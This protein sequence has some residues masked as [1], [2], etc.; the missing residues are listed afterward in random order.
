MSDDRLAEIEAR[1]AAA[2]PGPWHRLDFA[3][4]ANDVWIGPSF[5]N[6]I[7]QVVPD[8][9][10]ADAAFIAHAREDVPWLLAE[11]RRLR[12]IEAAA[13]DVLDCCEAETKPC[14]LRQQILET[15]LAAKP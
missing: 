11:V 1:E 14:S 8:D 7:A 2:T 10:S 9:A 3:H 12:A 5:R 13:R 4:D 15:A 6:V